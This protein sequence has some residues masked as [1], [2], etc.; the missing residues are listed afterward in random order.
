MPSNLSMID[1]SFPTFT[2][3]EKPNEQIAQLANYMRLL[4]EQL[5]YQLKNLDTSNWN[6]KAMKDFQTDTT[7]DVAEELTKLAKELA[8]IS[9]RL[10]AVENLTGR[11][12]QAE[13]DI[14]YLEKER[15]AIE[16][17]VTDLE[18]SMED[19]VADIT[20]IAQVVQV[21][22]TGGATI[23]TAG[24]DI[25]LVGNIYVNGVKLEQGGET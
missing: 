7:S 2:G 22:G 21:D 15:E 9:S 10:A 19:C 6:K 20:N 16:E 11:M 23:G 14:A 4:V 18:T 3:R 12:N 24:K 13:T 8:S 5:Q 1:N 17:R 25:F